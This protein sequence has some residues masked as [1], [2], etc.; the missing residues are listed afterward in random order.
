LRTADPSE[1][2]RTIAARYYNQTARPTNMKKL[3]YILIFTST[4][5]I[6]SGQGVFVKSINGSVKR[7]KQSLNPNCA[8]YGEQNYVFAGLNYLV[9]EEPKSVSEKNFENYI[10]S[11]YPHT[12]PK[13]SVRFCVV[14][15][16]D[17]PP[18][19]RQIDI[20]DSLKM[21]TKQLDTL[22]KLVLKYPVF[23]KL[24]FNK[25]ETVKYLVINLDRF[26]KFAFSVGFTTDFSVRQ[27]YS[28]KK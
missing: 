23:S 18:C 22:T 19:C 25:D 2:R 9:D 7:Q 16:P 20:D 1:T 11:N 10:L 5:S 6:V 17:I 12:F 8:S 24:Q 26:K 13:M 27:G 28:S 15:Q 3:F 4:F 14:F 21:D